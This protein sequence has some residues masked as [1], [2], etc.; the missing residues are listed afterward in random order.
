M[1]EAKVQRS[2]RSQIFPE[3]EF[4]LS[5]NAVATD[6]GPSLGDRTRLVEIIVYPLEQIVSCE[7]PCS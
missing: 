1:T 7:S 2:L 3:Q 4:A 6:T 5:S